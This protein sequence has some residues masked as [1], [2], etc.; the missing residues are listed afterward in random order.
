MKEQNR[1]TK[2]PNTNTGNEVTCGNFLDGYRMQM[3][4]YAA[5]LSV[6]ALADFLHYDLPPVLRGLADLI[7]QFDIPSKIN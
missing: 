1:T 6:H 5:L 4:A 3:G 7:Q 2:L